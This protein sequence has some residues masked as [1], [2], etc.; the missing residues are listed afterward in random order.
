PATLDA[1]AAADADSGEPRG[2][3]YALAPS[4]RDARVVWAGT[5][6]GLV[7]LTT[8]GAQTWRDVTP[9][10]TVA[11]T[12]VD[13]I[14]A[15]HYD[16]RS[17]YVALDRHRLDDDR[18]DIEATRDGGRTWRSIATG[19][20]DDASVNVVRE[21]PVRPG[22][23]FAGT[24]TGVYVSF[25][26][27]NAWQSLRL[28]MP[29]VSVRDIAV[30]DG[31]LAIATHGRAFWILDDIEPLRELA[32]QPATGARLFAP[33]DA[34][35]MR[36][37]ND[38]AEATPPETSLG[39]N[40]P[41]GAL[42]D[43]VVAPQNRGEVRIEISS[44][45]R[46]VRRWSS[47]DSSPPVDPST[48]DFPAYWLEKP[49]PPRATPG[50]HRFVWDFRIGSADG[51]LAPPGTYAVRLTV[52]DRTFAQSFRVRRDPRVRASDADLV[53]SSLLAQ[54]IDALHARVRDVVSHAGATQ[55]AALRQ[56]GRLL[57]ELQAAVESADAAPTT[58]ERARWALLA[59]RTRAALVAKVP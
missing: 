43:Y 57:A 52:D 55:F 21:D 2:V 18:P 51:P 9:P 29:V 28:N 34:I 15:S 7:K 14:E 39:E 35:R 46:V 30:H 44:G 20:P 17:A 19:L 59:A 25:D 49:L 12:H 56:D 36:S 1:P 3:L 41:A 27:G 11:W 32:A 4:P 54:A 53:A 23:L 24:E 40:P 16:A 45:G 48:V 13:T 58:D 33:R 5:D 10:G 47:A 37:G 31:D 8:N 38:E 22:L 26:D 6:D 42:I 50:M